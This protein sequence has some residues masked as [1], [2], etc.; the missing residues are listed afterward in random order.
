MNLLACIPTRE[1]QDMKFPAHIITCSPPSMNLLAHG[2][3]SL[4]PSLTSQH[5]NENKK[6]SWLQRY[7]LSLPKRCQAT[8]L[9]RLLG[10]TTSSPDTRLLPDPLS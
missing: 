4:F 1:Y 10:G 5:D 9:R 7:R 2:T 3:T 8:I 6:S